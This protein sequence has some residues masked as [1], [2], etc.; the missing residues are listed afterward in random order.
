[1]KK[2]IGAA[3]S[4]DA[5]AARSFLREAESELDKA[6]GKGAMHRNTTARIKRRLVR[7]VKALS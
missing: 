5:E 2:V 7:R 4:G 6:A 3:Y 1:M